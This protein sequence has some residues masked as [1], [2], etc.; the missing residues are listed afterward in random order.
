MALVFRSYMG[1]SSHW[2]LRGVSDRAIDYQ[3]WAGPAQGAF[4]DWVTGSFL[5]PLENRSVVQIALNLLE[6][7]ACLTRAQQLS[8][9]GIPVPRGAF[10]FV[11]RP[12]SP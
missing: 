10:D 11:P 2:P 5:E 8:S 12:L 6:G 3:I 9:H 7:A 4:N 1:Q